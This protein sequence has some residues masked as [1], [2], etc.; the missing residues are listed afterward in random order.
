MPRRTAQ[1]PAE[2]Q[3]L[4]A[5]D[6]GSNSFHLI[7]ARQDGGHLQVI[8]KLREMVRLAAGLDNEKNLSEK[9]Q[10]RALDCLERFGQRLR[11]LPPGSVRAVGT[12]TLR[13]ARNSGEFLAAAQ[14]RLGH[15]I[16]IIAGREE[17]RL[18]YLGVAHGL[19]AGQEPRLVVDIGGGS[20]EV[21]VGRGFQSRMRESLHMG[22]VSM[23]RAHF[24][25]GRIDPERM[26]QAEIASRLELRPVKAQFALAGWKTAVGSSGTIRAIRDV[27]QAAGW[28]DAGISRESMQELRKTMIEAG[29]IEKLELEGLSNERKPVFVGGFAVLNAVFKALG[30]NRM[31]VSDEALREG[32]L[33]DLSGRMRQQ[34]ARDRTV[35]TLCKRYAIDMAHAKRIATTALDYLHQ[36]A[37]D[38]E[39]ADPGYADMLRWAARLHE[40]GLIMAHN[41]YH[42]HGAYLIA[43]SDMSGFSRQEQATLAA[44][45]RGHRRKFP[46]ATFRHLG[47]QIEQPMRRLCVLLRLAALIHRNRAAGRPRRASLHIGSSGSLKVQ[48]DDGWLDH[49]AMTRADLEQEEKYLKAAGIKMK[50]K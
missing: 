1:P 5:V 21:I 24:A 42:K 39:L 48:F 47:E 13:L 8:D 45:I 28:S 2:S 44:L 25:D 7:V 32:L 46:N 16:Q 27:V 3:T 15:P 20:T 41:Q 14:R 36:V 11:T 6:L 10:S 37:E 26:R 4:A 12:N 9:A 49:H 29:S 31:Q 35:S 18:V 22:C 50:F 23:S 17:A 19:A 40:V 30:I 34:D 43:N 38:W 33:Y